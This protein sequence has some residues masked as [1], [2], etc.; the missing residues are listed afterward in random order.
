MPKKETVIDAG[1]DRDIME[2][3]RHKWVAQFQLETESG[4][5]PVRFYP[6]EDAPLAQIEWQAEVEAK[7]LLS[8]DQSNGSKVKSI[9]NLTICRDDY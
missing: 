2:P 5:R 8:M 6:N 1:G 4:I 9:R 7:R 3:E